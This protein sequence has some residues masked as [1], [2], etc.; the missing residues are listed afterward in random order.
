MSTEAQ[1]HHDI[2]LS[3]RVRLA[4]NVENLFFPNRMS[5]EMA[6][7]AIISLSAPLLR[8]AGDGFT[9]MRLDQGN[10]L[11]ARALVERHLISPELANSQRTRGVVLSVDERLSIM[12][13]EEDH[14]RI[15][16]FGSGLCLE[17]CLREA[18]R[19]DDLI[20]GAVAYAF[21]EH[22]GFLTACP[23]NL[24]TGLRASVMLHLPALTEAGLMRDIVAAVGKMG[25][26]ARGL[27]GEGSEAYGALYQMSNQITLGQNEEEI[28]GHV[29]NVALRVVDRERTLRARIKKSQTYEYEDRVWRAMGILKHARRLPGE[30]G[31]RLLSDLRWGVS[32]GDLDLPLSLLDELLEGIQPGVLTLG[33]MRP[34]RAAERDIARA[35]Y[36]R[37]RLQG[38]H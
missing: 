34:L 14:L 19:I 7:E 29:S 12:L 15:Q 25:L 27:Y 35:N 26:A 9:L 24:G 38:L 30:E 17:N 32:M 8:A 5:R 10:H 4:R 3:T 6:E 21:D 18:L 2:A 20:G 1:Y 22:L 28:I 36:V 11:E 31:M 23:T 37:E 13:C 16:S 33:A